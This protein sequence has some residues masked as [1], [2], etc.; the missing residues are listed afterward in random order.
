MTKLTPTFTGTASIS[1]MD[2]RKQPGK[3]V[4]RVS[5]RNESFVIERAGEAKAVIVSVRD[6]AEMKRLR[7]DAKKRLFARIDK[8][9]KR[10]AKLDPEKVEKTIE[11]AVEAVRRNHPHKP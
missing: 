2:L 11:E 1:M 5:Y 3:V 4:D 8:V 6:F 10:T 7:E 9:Y